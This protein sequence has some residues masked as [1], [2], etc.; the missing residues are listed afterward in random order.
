MAV[1][2]SPRQFIDEGLLSDLGTLLQETGINPELLELEITES[3]VMGNIERAAM[4]L[5]AIKQL[6][7]RFALDDFG[8]GYSSLAQIKRFPIDT[9]KVDRSFIQHVP[10]NTEDTAMMEAIITMGKALKLTVV[11]EGVETSAQQT[12]LAT[13][14]CDEMQGYFF[15]RPIS[16][17][18]FAD[19]LR[20]NA[21]TVEN[22][23]PHPASLLA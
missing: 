23:P 19:L 11:A 15:S 6:G 8:T 2:L 3:M 16:P 4:K 9:L 22:G 20:E 5:S 1:N 21:A 14:N 12:F 10:E 18:Q 17:E 7:V 13:H